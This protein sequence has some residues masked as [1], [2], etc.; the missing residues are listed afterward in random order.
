MWGIGRASL[1]KLEAMGVESV[2]DLRDLDPRPVRKGLTVVGE[3]ISTNCAGSPACPRP[4]AGE[5][6]GCA[7]TRAFSSR[8]TDRAT[9]WE[10]VAAHATRLGEKLGGKGSAPITSRSSTIRAS[11]TGTRRSARSPRRSVYPS[12]PRTR[13][14]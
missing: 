1:A 13:W 12:T 4:R 7:V 6:E 5:A 2:A 11:T 3:R 10:A 14:R 9:L 8:I